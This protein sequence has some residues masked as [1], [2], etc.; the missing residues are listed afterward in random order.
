M[1]FSFTEKKAIWK[2]LI[3]I[4]GSDGRIST[5]EADYGARLVAML[6][7]SESDMDEALELT[8][9]QAIS[10]LKEMTPEKKQSA[11]TMLLEMVKVDGAVDED[12]MKIFSAI[13]TA[14][15]LPLPE[16]KKVK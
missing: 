2:L 6:G 12:E 9:K 15:E 4:I 3:D 10:I 13:C 11:Q 16:F 14:A 7:F 1:N 8:V 5:G